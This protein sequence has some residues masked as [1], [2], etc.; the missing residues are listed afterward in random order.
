MIRP[1]AGE[2]VLEPAR[3]R[4]RAAHENFRV[5]SRLLPRRVRQGLLAIYGVARLIDEAGD[6]A[7]GDRAAL[8]DDLERDVRAGL[9]GDGGRPEDPLIREL[10]P[11]ARKHGIGPQPF[12]DLIEA[13]RLDQRRAR[14]ATFEDLLAYCALSAN[15]VGRLVLQVLDRSDERTRPLSDDI[16]TG[17][18][19]AE[20]WQDVREDLGRGRIYLPQED[21]EAFGVSERDLAAPSAG[22]ALRALMDFEVARAR[23]LLEAGRP[24][25][26]VLG[27][28]AG[29]AIRGFVAGG[30]EALDGIG[31]AGFDVLSAPPAVSRP[32]RAVR[33]LREALPGWS[34]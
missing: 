2:A 27:G 8:L 26:G 16:C 24:L 18:Q 14:Y 17:L 34:L 29:W 31:R 30:L 21:L 22:P 13:N 28:R 5:V 23:V 15:P 7:P 11:V 20:H 4:R 6:E 33:L 19:L 9:D 32:R 10:Q 3:I 12:L 1:R 25:A